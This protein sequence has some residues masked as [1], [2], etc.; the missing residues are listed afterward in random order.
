MPEVKHRG[1]CLLV[2]CLPGQHPFAVTA[3][4]FGRE[5]V[6]EE[7]DLSA[8]CDLPVP[9][10]RGRK[11]VDAVGGEAAGEVPETGRLRIKLEALAA[12]TLVL[13]GRQR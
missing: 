7:F 13:S 10:L 8:V 1:V 2:L 9:K 3:L 6:E 5:P 4:N 12:K 11:L